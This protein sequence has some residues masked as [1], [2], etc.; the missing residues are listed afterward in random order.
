MILWIFTAKL[1]SIYYLP[2]FVHWDSKAQRLT[3]GQVHLTAGP[4]GMTT[5]ITQGLTPSGRD[6]ESLSFNEPSTF[7]SSGPGLPWLPC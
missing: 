3:R 1:N 5:D 7:T 6:S 4:Q 2:Y